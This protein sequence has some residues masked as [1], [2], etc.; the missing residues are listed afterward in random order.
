MRRAKGAGA[1]RSTVLGTQQGRDL[2]S[3]GSA[4]SAGGRRI[5]RKVSQVS[6]AATETPS[7]CLCFIPPRTSCPLLWKKLR[8]QHL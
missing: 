7:S 5:V 1:G 4:N 2:G 6:P 8:G 3:R